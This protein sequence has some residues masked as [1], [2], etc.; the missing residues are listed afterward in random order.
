MR[1]GANN[2]RRLERIVTLRDKKESRFERRACTYRV[3]G[4]SETMGKLLPVAKIIQDREAREE[5]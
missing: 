3:K 2:K 5:G 4:T 1:G